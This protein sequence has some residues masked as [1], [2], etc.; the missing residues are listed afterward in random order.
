MSPSIFSKH[1]AACGKTLAMRSS[2]RVRCTCGA[3]R[4]PLEKRSSCRLRFAAQRHRVLKIGEASEACSSR[5]FVVISV[6]NW[7]TSDKRKAVLLGERD[8]DAVVRRRGLQFEIES[9]AESLAQRQPPA[10]C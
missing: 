9:A 4:L 3:M 6:R 8:V 2:E 5:S 7:K 10:P 1:A